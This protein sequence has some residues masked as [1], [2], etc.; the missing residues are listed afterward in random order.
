[1]QKQYIKLLIRI[2][3]LYF[4]KHDSS[5]NFV[6]KSYDKVSSGYDEA[7]TGHMRDLTETVI[8]KLN[9]QKGNL[10]IDLT[11][12]TGFATN[13][14]AQKTDTKVLGVDRSNGMLAQANKNY[15]QNCEFIQ[16]DIL[17]YLKKQPSSSFDIITCC[18]GLGYS[19]PFAVLRQIKRILKHGGKV[20]IIDNSL[21][22]LREILYC[23]FLTFAEQPEKLKNLMKFR[24][25][26]NAGT[27]KLMFRVLNM[28]PLYSVNGSKSYLVDSGREAIEKLTATG[29]AAGFEYAAEPGTNEQIFKR[30]AE[31]IEEKHLTENGI[32][33]TH[34]Y[35][36]G[37]AEK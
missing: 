23:S 12:G 15:W 2:I 28:K 37:I 22:S 19:K 32:A 10:A 9:P 7:W 4:Q 31:I 29:A 33:I 6:K 5:N 14:I 26:P 18:W 8:N 36:T 17:E 24:F 3:C 27:L 35:F 25:L 20:G 21:F 11:C 13:L 16:A 34:R 1:M 30:F